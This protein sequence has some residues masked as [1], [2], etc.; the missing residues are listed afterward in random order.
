MTSDF[1]LFE[2]LDSRCSLIDNIILVNFP[3]SISLGLDSYNE[4]VDWDV[5]LAR[6]GDVLLHERNDDLSLLGH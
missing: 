2:S 6:Y 1:S 5:L 3:K 4:E